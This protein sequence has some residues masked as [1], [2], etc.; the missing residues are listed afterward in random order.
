MSRTWE[1]SLDEAK[2][3]GAPIRAIVEEVLD[4]CAAYIGGVDNDGPYSLSA[5]LDL[6]RQDKTS[7][8][9]V[10]RALRQY[11]AGKIESAKRLSLDLGP[12][13]V[14]VLDN[15][16]G[17]NEAREQCEVEGEGAK[18]MFQSVIQ[19]A[20][21]NCGRS[22]EEIEKDCGIDTRLARCGETI[23]T[24]KEF[25]MILSACGY[26]FTIEAKPRKPV[27]ATHGG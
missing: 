19:R 4:E 15:V 13:M 16:F 5:M 1:K 23:L 26:D 10:E 20:I 24:V 18:A 27:E 7:D 3:R 21:D 8:E 17:R 25:G 11:I 6:M 14:R 12:F 9:L 2:A 22:L